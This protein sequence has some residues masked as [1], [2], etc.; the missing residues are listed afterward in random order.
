MRRRGNETIRNDE[1]DG[2]ILSGGWRDER[3]ECVYL[4][5]CPRKQGR[6]GRQLVEDKRNNTVYRTN[7]LLGD[8]KHRGAN[9]CDGM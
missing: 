5:L 3:K 8:K 4:S 7:L 2:E 1:D 9:T 6:K